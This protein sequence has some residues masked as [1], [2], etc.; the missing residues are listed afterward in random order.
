MSR[1][2]R[3]FMFGRTAVVLVLVA[4]TACGSDGDA[5]TDQMT[6]STDTGTETT[7]ESTVTTVAAE[8]TVA[9]ADETTVAPA[10]TTVPVTT[11]A[12]ATT[13]PAT[14]TAAATSPPPPPPTAPPCRDVGLW[15]TAQLGDCGSGVVFI[16]ERLSVLGFAVSAD[17]VFG[18]GTEAAVSAFQASRGL[19]ADGIVG[20][21]TWAALVEGGIGD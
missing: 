8:P 10:T 1:I 5:A 16:Q 14:T 13:T 4:M 20:P 12:P 2:S 21:N 17:G 3:T 15:D 19:A 9:T 6:A 7:S 11:D 18:P